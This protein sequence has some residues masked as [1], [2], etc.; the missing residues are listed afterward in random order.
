MK[1]APSERLATFFRISGRVARVGSSG[2]WGIHYGS[3]GGVKSMCNSP[4]FF[5]IRP[6]H[7]DRRC[8][9]VPPISGLDCFV[10]S[11]TDYY[12]QRRA[13]SSRDSLPP[14]GNLPE[15]VAGLRMEQIEVKSYIGGLIKS[16]ERRAA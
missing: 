8:Q 16:F 9:A 1:V 4:P 11:F 5:K 14:T 10:D 12:N 7:N 6:S 13:H 2:R 3:L 15:E